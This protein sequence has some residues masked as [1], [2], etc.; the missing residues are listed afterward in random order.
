M[1]TGCISGHHNFKVMRVRLHR[2]WTNT[3]GRKYPIGQVLQVD[4]SL[5]RLLVNENYGTEYNGEY[6]KVNKVK[7]EF[8]KPT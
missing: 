6:P 1:A 7:T 8:F 3:Q 5:G 4:K 2:S